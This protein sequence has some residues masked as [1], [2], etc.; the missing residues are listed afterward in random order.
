M[1][2]ARIAAP[3]IAADDDVAPRQQ[4]IGGPDDAVDRALA[5][6]VAVVEEVLGLGVVDG[7]DRQLQHPVLLHGAEADHAGGRLFHARDDVA[8]QAGAIAR[9]ER[10][11]P[12]P[13]LGMEVVDPPERE[14][15]H[16][17]DQVGA[18]VHRHVRL[19]LQGLGDVPVIA[20]LILPLDRIDGD[21]EVLD[22]AGGDVVLGRQ[23][24]RGDQ[25][26]V[27][28][29]GDQGPGEVGGLGRHVQTGRHPQ[30]GQRLLGVEPL[31]DRAEHGHVSLRP[32]DPL[33][34]DTGQRQVFHVSLDRDGQERPSLHGLIEHEAG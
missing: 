25:D 9:R 30:A 1:P 26:Q 6:A 10:L 7:D 13:D 21:A 14:E 32:D 24:V 2:R 5:G 12:L 17:A 22:Q 3:A 4:H 20:R 19:V 27:R 18:V 23:R 8:D 29:A 31:A 16:G 33:V 28:T 34:A 11:A 15:D